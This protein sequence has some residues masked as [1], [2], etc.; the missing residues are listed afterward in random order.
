MNITMLIG[1][2]TKDPDV[3]KTNNGKT[4]A[5]FTLAIERNY[6]NQAGEKE[7]DYVPCVAW[8]KT[9]DIIGQYLHKGDLIAVYGPIQ[10]R[11]YEDKDKIKRYITELQVREMQMLSTKR[12][13][14]QKQTQPSAAK[15]NKY[16][17]AD[18]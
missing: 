10:T 17:A 5:T 3:K 18:A 9:A 15:E 1:R 14:G 8:E 11:N 13:D 7:A 6:K 12:S 2:L 4:V 16:T